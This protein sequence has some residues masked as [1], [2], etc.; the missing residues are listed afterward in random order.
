MFQLCDRLELLA[1]NDQSSFVNDY[2]AVSVNVWLAVLICELQVCW[3]T[4]VTNSSCLKAY[5]YQVPCVSKHF[6]PTSGDSFSIHP[7]RQH[8]ND[9]VSVSSQLSCFRDDALCPSVSGFKTTFA[10]YCMAISHL[11][12]LWWI[13]FTLQLR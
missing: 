1:K 5:L 8:K 13:T 12:G 10:W 11:L 3:V 9:E 6:T 2:I 4:M 7:D